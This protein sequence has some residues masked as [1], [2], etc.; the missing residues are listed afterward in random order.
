MNVT[1]QQMEKILQGQ[2]TFKQFGF[3]MLMTRLKKEY[4]A[5]P[6]PEKAEYSLKET[7]AFLDK[8]SSIMPE[9]LAIIAKI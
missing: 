9:E 6:T 2:Y 7:N 4:A 3:S 1:I 8:Y 5:E